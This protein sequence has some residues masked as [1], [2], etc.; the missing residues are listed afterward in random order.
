MQTLQELCRRTL[1]FVH[2]EQSVLD[3]S[4]YMVER[5]VGAVSVVENDR[6]AGIFSER[7]LLMRVVAAGDRKSTRLNSSHR[8]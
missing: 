8:L 6:L 4:R 2:P 5:N 1:Y 7:D 3:A